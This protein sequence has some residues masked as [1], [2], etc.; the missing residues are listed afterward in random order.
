MS[1]KPAGA[2]AYGDIA[3]TRKSIYDTPHN[4]GSVTVLTPAASYTVDQLIALINTAVAAA[5][6]TLPVKTGVAR[7][8][9]KGYAAALLTVDTLVG[10]SGYTNG[11]YTNVPLVSNEGSGYGALATITVSGG[12]VTSVT[13]TY[14]GTG[15]VV[16]NELTTRDSRLGAGT[17]FKVDV[18]TIS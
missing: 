13:I 14:G 5:N 3:N 11:T 15:Y 4:R 8:L 9:E 6:V 17:G 16:D 10:G 1:T 12:A 7:R 18:A 2:S